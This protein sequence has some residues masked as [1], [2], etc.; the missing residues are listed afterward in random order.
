LRIRL[1]IT[2]L[3]VLIFFATQ[4]PAL[5]ADKPGE[6]ADA[7]VV[8]EQADCHGTDMLPE[9]QA[10]DAEAYGR[11]MR[12]AETTE[13][14]NALFW[15]VEKAGVAPSYLLGTV[16]LTDARVATLSPKV[17]ETIGQS[18][19]VL[20]EV[21]DLTAS[22]TANALSE[23][24]KLAI[25]TDGQSL[26]KILSREEYETVQATLNRAGLP[27]ETARLFK[28]WIVTMLLAGSD[29]ER[30]K[31]QEGVPVLDMKIAEEAKSR[32]IPVAGLETLESQLGALASVP[33]EQQIDMLRASL[34]FAGRT[35]DL[36]ETMLQ[37]YV[38]RQL[39]ATWPLQIALAAKAG[40]GETSFA[41]FKKAIIDERNA[42]MRDGAVPHLDKGGAFIAVGALHLPGK[43]GL[44]ELLRAAGY[45]VTAVE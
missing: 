27:I 10:T 32:G 35:N 39:G 14:G 18:T 34:K 23:A 30:R 19:R 5:A 21:A 25:F 3:G 24:T 13:N 12:E 41:G 28:P 44:I 15:K 37:L 11:I 40:V 22:A 45:T 38:K 43:S 17:I 2:A 8:A 42:K 20:L 33:Q 26:D 36:V 6:N 31:I 9:L 7:P 29:C 4:R 16:H 1:S